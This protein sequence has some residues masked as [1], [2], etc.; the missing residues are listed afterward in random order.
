MIQNPIISIVGL[1]TI[2]VIAAVS[3]Y[4]S[5]KKNRAPVYIYI[6]LLCC[7]VLIAHSTISFLLEK[8]NKIKSFSSIVFAVILLYNVSF[9]IFY[10]IAKYRLICI[11]ILSA[12]SGSVVGASI[13][14]HNIYNILFSIILCVMIGLIAYDQDHII[15][16]KQSLPQP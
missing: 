4:Y 9:R 11:I 6:L 2:A 13:M 12:L 10:L 16:K 7:V 8:E 14:Q 5:W 15:K 1:S 3:F